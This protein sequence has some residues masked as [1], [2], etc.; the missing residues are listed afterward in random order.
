MD[1]PQH[2]PMRKRFTFATAIVFAGL[3]IILLNGLILP[4]TAV[5]LQQGINSNTSSSQ[6][7][8]SFSSNRQPCYN[9]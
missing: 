3:I 1:S 4:S 5:A 7:T 6:S 2:K 9:I 8:N